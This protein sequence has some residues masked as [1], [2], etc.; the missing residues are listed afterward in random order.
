MV[1][2]RKIKR[3]MI[4]NK[5]TYLITF[6]LLI[7]STALFT[8]FNTSI[9]EINENINQ[10]KQEYKV[11]DANFSVANRLL[12]IEGLETKF[13]IV[14]EEMKY[15]D[16]LYNNTYIR[17][18]ENRS[19]L[20]LVKGDN[21][22][23]K[24]N[25]NQMYINKE[26]YDN[27]DLSENDK[28]KINNKTFILKGIS[29][30]PDYIHMLQNTSSV[31]A[32]K[33]SFAVAFVDKND[34]ESFNNPNLCYG[35]KFNKNNEKEFKKYI[36]ENNVLT[37]WTD[38]EDDLKISAINGDLEAFSVIGDTVPL[39]IILLVSLLIGIVLW[40][41]V[42]N[43]ISQ[44]GTLYALGYNKKKIIKHYMFY[45]LFIT[46][47]S[48]IVGQVVSFFCTSIFKRAIEIEYSLPEF[49]INPNLK[50]M[51][52]SI[53]L[54]I[55]IIVP[56][57][58]IV[59]LFTLKHKPI[60]LIKNKLQD[61]KISILEK[62]ISRTK[63]SFK[64]KFQIKDLARNKGRSVL[65]F[66]S[67]VFSSILLFFV[68]YITDSLDNII[69]KGYDEPNQYL[70]MYNMES[71]GTEDVNGSKIWNIPVY[72]KQKDNK[73]LSFMLEGHDKNEKLF[74][75]K[76]EEDNR[77]SFEDVI[78]TQ[79]LAKRL[80]VKQGDTVQFYSNLDETIFKVKIDKIAKTYLND[81]LYVPIDLI[82]KKTEIPKGSYSCII[83]NDKI[84]FNN[85]KLAS[86]T[87]K[88]D[89]LVGIFNLVSPLSYIMYFVGIVA[90]I[91]GAAL[92]YVIISMVI[93]E[94][95]INISM[96]K[97][98]GYS[99]KK[100][101]SIILNLNDLIVLFAYICSIFISKYV[102]NMLFIKMTRNTQYTLEAKISIDSVLIVTGILWLIY[103]FSKIVTRR[104]IL[105]IP[106]DEVLKNERE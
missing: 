23:I 16:V 37:S 48:G 99:N 2:N 87:T 56:L 4:H 62:L 96:F 98:L 47:I 77:L 104:K 11:A 81:V 7:L 34:F 93:D 74:V 64:L 44:L 71:Y 21:S 97:I 73:E 58:L 57:N 29:N 83:S 39:V 36:N 14:I 101:T 55:V 30:S 43:E 1:L 61:N 12:D 90:S 32:N 25:D 76:D 31:F 78:I 63:L 59:I 85:D 42:R 15:K 8:V 3:N 92:I 69:I 18:Y 35:I 102:I 75:L 72:T 80:D 38:K 106:M 52:I 65:T 33:Q 5:S 28:I 86:I 103:E 9:Y 13:N 24:I 6:I 94:N 67:I 60:D 105:K 17:I 91:I 66:C 88:E 45:P 82:Y 40:R 50:Y 27:H 68:F 19:K 51:I 95:K 53:L 70:Y 54:P 84:S 22:L 100:I 10:F 49:S 79:S 26:F 41:L 46:T 89:M 20:N